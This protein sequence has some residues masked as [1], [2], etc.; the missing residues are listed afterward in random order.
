MG[1]N[2]GTVNE[3]GRIGLTFNQGLFYWPR[4]LGEGGLGY[5]VDGRI[6]Y[7]ALGYRGATTGVLT[8]A[9]ANGNY[10]SST[11]NSTTT[12][13]Y[14]NFTSTDV[15]PSNTGTRAYGFSVRCLSE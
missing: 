1:S 15:G 11:P 5:P 14:L 9:G 8:A 13:R 12:G 4:L 7:P 6:F 3:S 10:W 2:P